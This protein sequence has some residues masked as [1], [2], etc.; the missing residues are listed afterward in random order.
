MNG[1]MSLSYLTLSQQLK[2]KKI[3]LTWIPFSWKER[4]PVKIGGLLSLSEE[5]ILSMTLIKLDNKMLEMLL[6]LK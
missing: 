5:L 1:I 6:L 4:T 2:E 3:G